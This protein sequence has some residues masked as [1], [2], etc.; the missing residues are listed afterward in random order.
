MSA[1]YEHRD[2]AASFEEFGTPRRLAGAEGWLLERPIPGSDLRDAMGCY[3][4]FCCGQWDRL[5][6]DI[7][8]LGTDLV[9]VV[10]A[11]DPFCPVGLDELART[12]DSVISFKE[13]FVADLDAPIE[14]IVKR[15][16]RATVR[17]AQ[18]TV[19]VSV[20]LEPWRHLDRW[21][22]LFENLKAR[23]AIGGLRAFSRAAFE[24]QL[25]VP[26][27]V[28]FEAWSGDELVGLDLWYEQ[29]DVAYGHL[30]AFNEAGYAARASYATKWAVLEHF[31]GRVRWVD[32]GGGAG[33][34]DADDGLT[35]FKRGWSNATRTVF[36]CG[37][38]LQSDAY[39]RLAVARGATDT[40]YFPAYRS[41]ELV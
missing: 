36:L 8:A 22:E 34:A 5:G 31:R 35:Q 6:A 28:M 21:V 18:K 40:T 30:V 2:Y 16:H 9:S 39:E 27:M 23:H 32:L 1:G 19:A 4:L 25:R 37:R 29:G 24:L 41:G 12:F 33:G 17:R 11:T 38:I 7:D 10:L 15:S 13:H 3:P 26:G 20:C 14:Q